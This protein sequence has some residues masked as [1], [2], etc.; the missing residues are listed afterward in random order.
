V[1]LPDVDAAGFALLDSLTGSN[2]GSARTWAAVNLLVDEIREEAPERIALV[3]VAALDEKG[4][5]I[6]SWPAE[7]LAV[8]A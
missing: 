2:I 3:L 1:T 4:Q 8:E 7:A 6:D 5:L